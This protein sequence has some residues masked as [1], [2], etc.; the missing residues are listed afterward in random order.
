MSVILSLST[1]AAERTRPEQATSTTSPHVIE[2]RARNR[3][4]LYIG[5]GLHSARQHIR[6]SSYVP[7]KSTKTCAAL[8]EDAYSNATPPPIPRYLPV[9][10]PRDLAPHFPP[11]YLPRH[12]LAHR[13]PGLLTT[14]PRNPEGLCDKIPRGP[15][16]G[17]HPLRPRPDRRRWPR[18]PDARRHGVRSLRGRGREETLCLCREPPYDG[19]EGSLTY[20]AWVAGV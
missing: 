14:A 11:A 6:T 19:K 2:R 18:L 16:C 9:P 8:F 13:P 10:P 7:S 5:T 12:P 17:K 3:Q 1:L 20:R 4:D 15:G